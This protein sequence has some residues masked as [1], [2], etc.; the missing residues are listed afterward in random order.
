[1]SQVCMGGSR[2]T[3][4]DYPGACKGPEATTDRL[5]RGRVCQPVAVKGQNVI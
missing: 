4:R 2:V 1:M 3:A 5:R